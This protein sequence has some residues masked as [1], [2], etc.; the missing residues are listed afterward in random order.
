MMREELTGRRST[1]HGHKNGNAER[2][3]ESAE[4]GVH[5]GAGGEPVGGQTR[6]GG[7]REQR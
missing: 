5:G 3:T 6:D 2:L 7:R 1:D 4:R